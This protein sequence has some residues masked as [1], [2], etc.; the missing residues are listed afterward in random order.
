MPVRFRCDTCNGKLSIATRKIGMPVECPRCNE[1][2]LVPSASQ[3]GE[4]LTELLLS[5]GGARREAVG[6]RAPIPRPG[7]SLEEMPLFE[8]DDIDEM[9]EPLGKEAAPLPLPEP[10]AAKIDPSA[11]RDDIVISRTRATV[12]AVAVFALVGLAFGLG[13]IVRGYAVTGPS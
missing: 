5:V 9:L 10:V 8:R 4:E 1:S 11:H 12:F 13:Y 3:I 2:M 6:T 7:R